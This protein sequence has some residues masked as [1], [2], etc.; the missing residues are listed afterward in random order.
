MSR[1]IRY[2]IQR[3]IIF[4]PDPDKA[5]RI[6]DRFPESLIMFYQP[7]ELADLGADNVRAVLEEGVFRGVGK[8][9]L[10]RFQLSPGDPELLELY[11][12]VAQH[13]AGITIKPNRAAGPELAMQAVEAVFRDHPETV[14]ILGGSDAGHLWSGSTGY[15]AAEYSNIYFT[16]DFD[17]LYR[18]RTGTGLQGFYTTETLLSDFESKFESNL[19]F[20]ESTLKPV[21]EANPDR[22]LWGTEVPLVGQAEYDQAILDKIIAF[23]R[24][25]LGRL[26]LLVA[27]QVGYA[28]AEALLSTISGQ[29]GP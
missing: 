22:F 13:G 9:D 26:D 12:I 27:N 14:F 15:L 3:A 23:S 29:A 8:V 4:H 21:I 28:N 1:L 6:S 11:P 18:L 24:V 10:D 7:T 17:F 20:A 2:S 5:G 19:E 16:V 25:F